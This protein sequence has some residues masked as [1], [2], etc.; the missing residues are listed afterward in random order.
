MRLLSFVLARPRALL[1]NTFKNI[2]SATVY[3]VSSHCFWL[4]L[5]VDDNNSRGFCVSPSPSTL[6][7]PDMQQFHPRIHARYEVN[8]A[9]DS[10]PC[11]E[12][13]HC[14]DVPSSWRGLLGSI[15]KTRERWWTMMRE[16]LWLAALTGYTGCT[17]GYK[18]YNIFLPDNRITGLK[19]LPWI[20]LLD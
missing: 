9:I 3:T 7:A 5:G 16:V 18:M 12:L 19:Y 8:N 17:N 10:S 2:A 11:L 1:Q 4:T 20:L 13:R 14:C 15:S 6:A